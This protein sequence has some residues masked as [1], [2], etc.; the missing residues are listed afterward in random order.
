M[1]VCFVLLLCLS[2]GR[3]SELEAEVNALRKEVSDLEDRNVELCENPF[4][5]DAAERRVRVY[6]RC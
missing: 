6:F 1:C 4:V 2:T 5:N 3:V